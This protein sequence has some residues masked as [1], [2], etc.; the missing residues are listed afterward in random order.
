MAANVHIEHSCERAGDPAKVRA[1]RREKYRARLAM[2]KAEREKKSALIC[3]K[4]WKLPEYQDADRLLV[5]VSYGAEVSTHELIRRAL[6]ENRKVYC[7]RVEGDK[8]TFYRIFSFSDL[9][10]GYRGIPEPEAGRERFEVNASGCHDRTVII[11][12]GTA[13][14]P[15]GHRIGYGGGYY[16]RFLG[17]F[18][19]SSRPFCVG[20]GFDCQLTK[21]TPCEHDVDMDLVL[22]A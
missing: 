4:L 19:G 13:F 14:D 21:I 6:T 9:R 11:V 18:P 12:P 17:E 2:S 1:L 16:D 20:L 8:I 10:P 15:D 22:F 5:Y 7:P 3:E